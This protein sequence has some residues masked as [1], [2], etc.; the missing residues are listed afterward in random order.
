ML[1]NH[2]TYMGDIYTYTSEIWILYSI[3]YRRKKESALKKVLLNSFNDLT[4]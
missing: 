2:M 4:V 1:F 3:V